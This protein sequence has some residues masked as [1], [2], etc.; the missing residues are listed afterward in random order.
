MAKFCGKCGSELNEQ[1]KC[2]NCVSDNN[3]FF[4]LSTVK[5]KP[6][7]G[8]VAI[9]LVLAIIIGTISIISVCFRKN[10]PE[11]GGLQLP[12][13]GKFTNKKITDGRSA[14]KA[15]QEIADDLGL[16]NATDELTVKREDTVGELTYYRLQ[17]N[18]KGIPVYGSD[19]IVI[20]DENGEA[21]G[22]TGNAN[23]ID[24]SIS[25]MP[26]VTQEQVEASIQ[27]HFGE[28]SE[29]SV[30]KLSD[31]MLIV[32]NYGDI[33]NAELAYGIYV[34]AS[35]KTYRILIGAQSNIIYKCLKFR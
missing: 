34:V 27:A 4:S 8:I 24:K 18:Y 19:F 2:P 11:Q 13:V 30:P 12:I 32:Y 14:I 7:I 1:G 26:T 17:Q 6:W 16:E 10:D 25:L 5:K 28:E 9:V 33:D 20:A 21:K 22:V 35:E 15:V 3:K 29:V 31:E 23:D